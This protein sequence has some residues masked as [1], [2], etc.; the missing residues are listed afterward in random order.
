M[1]TPRSYIVENS[2]STLTFFYSSFHIVIDIT[3]VIKA[4]KR[5]LLIVDSN[6]II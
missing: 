6:I 5:I 1:N 2:L 3:M 4:F